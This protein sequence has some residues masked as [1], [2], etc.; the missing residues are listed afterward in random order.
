LHGIKEK[1]MLRVIFIAFVV[2]LF[3]RIVFYPLNENQESV[4]TGLIIAIFI[5]EF[6]INPPKNK[7]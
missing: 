1:E 2:D 5:Y 4:L 7:T 6:F 3:T